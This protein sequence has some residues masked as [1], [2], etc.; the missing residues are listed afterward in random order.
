MECLRGAARCRSTRSGRSSRTSRRWTPIDRSPRRRARA[1]STCRPEKERRRVETRG[2]ER[3]SALSL[4]G[5]PCQL[6]GARHRKPRGDANHES[7]LAA[8][9]GHRRRLFGGHCRSRDRAHAPADSRNARGRTAPSAC[10][11]RGR[12]RFDGGAS[13]AA[14][15]ERPRRPRGGDAGG[16][17]RAANPNRR[18]SVVVGSALSGGPSQRHRDRCQRNP[19][20]GGPRRPVGA[21]FHRRD[22]QLLGAESQR[23]E[24]PD[25]RT[26]DATPSST[27]TDGSVRRTV[28][29]IL[30]LSAR[31]HGV[32]SDRRRA[33]SF[34]DVARLSTPSGV[35]ADRRGRPPWTRGVSLV[36]VRFLPHRPGRR[37]LRTQGPRLNASGEPPHDRLGDAPQHGWTA[38][39]LD[40]GF[41][42]HQAG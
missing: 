6:L 28:R 21:V 16:T 30:R 19:R 22:P 32:R 7:S 39:R 27:R 17:W 2:L 38:G 42:T 1:R 15:G 13:V 41:A 3:C 14:D 12:N 26:A 10:G 25:P 40:C 20:P 8:V 4:R 36:C 31:A 29:G 11:R 9:L 23:Q 35:R 5:V 37:R 34:R 18:P 24:R 33:G